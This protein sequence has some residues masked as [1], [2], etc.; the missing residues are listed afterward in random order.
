MLCI[1]EDSI[2]RHLISF[3]SA[4]FNFLALSPVAH[5][6]HSKPFNSTRS[7][8]GSVLWLFLKSM[9]KPGLKETDVP[10]GKSQSPK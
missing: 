6:T 10:K 7:K 1:L 8:A 9:N 3:P 2:G 5:L 4:A